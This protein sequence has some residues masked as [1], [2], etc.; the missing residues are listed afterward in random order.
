MLSFISI[1]SLLFVRG[2]LALLV[3][4]TE[5]AINIFTIKT[6]ERYNITYVPNNGS[7][8][9]TNQVIENHPIGTFPNIGEYNDCENSTGTYDERICTYAYE[10]EG[11]Y[12]EATFENEVTESFVPTSDMTLY[13]KWNKIYFR[14]AEPTTFTGNSFIDTEIMLFNQTNAARDFIVTFVVDTLGENQENRAAIFADMYEKNDPY[15]GVQFRWFNNRYNVNA[16]VRGNKKN[17]GVNY[18]PGNKV[19]LKRIDGVFS[20]SLD[21]GATYTNYQNFSNFTDY[22]DVNATFGGQYDA[23]G[24]GWRYFKGT[25]SDMKVEILDPSKYTIHFNSNG[26]TG[27]MLDQEIEI[28]APVALSPCTFTRDGYK[29]KSWNTRADGTGTT[30]TNKQVVNS[31]GHSNE[32]VNLYAIW[33]AAEYYYIHFDANGGTGTMPNQRFIIGDNT[34]QSLNQYAFTRDGYVFRNWNTNADGSGTTYED[35]QEITSDLTTTPNTTINLYAQYYRK[36]YS[37]E[38]TY[39]FDGIDDYIDTGV[40]I[41]AQNTMNKDFEIGFTINYVDPDNAILG[42]EQP[43]ILNCKDES[44]PLWP[45]FVVRLPDGSANSIRIM[46]KWNGVNGQTSAQ[47]A[48]LSPNNVP[49][50]IIF[51]RQGDDITVRYKY[52]NTDSGDLALY[53]QTSWTLNQYFPDNVTFGSNYNDQHN[54]D[55]FFKGTLSNM[56]ILIED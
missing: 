49:I 7:S 48:S 39:T 19:I 35:M 16:N 22:F 28:G 33:E 30:Y 32:V 2:V 15:Q 10:F 31:I 23:D 56:Y 44:N 18:T 52:G 17:T 43:T 46:Y 4:I 11:W 55:R 24:N 14:H 25:L 8:N 51:K 40:N 26:G 36:A 54:P 42:Q 21:G 20:Y 50:D 41:F 5:P 37:Y 27:T 13:A 47:K 1:I 34:T 9:I 6:I 38:G 3:D 29:F 12:K 45:G 53:N